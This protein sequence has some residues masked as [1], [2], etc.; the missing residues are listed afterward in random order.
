MA[1]GWFFYDFLIEEARQAARGDLNVARIRKSPSIP[2]FQ[3]DLYPESTLLDTGVCVASVITRHMVTMSSK[4][5][6]PIHRVCVPGSPSLLR[7]RNPPRPATRGIA[8]RKVGGWAGGTGFFVVNT[9]SAF[10]S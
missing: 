3:T 2:L 9:I 7:P 8:S 10:Q 4:R 5:C 1:V 6:K